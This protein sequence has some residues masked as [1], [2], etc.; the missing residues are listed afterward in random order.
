MAESK[1]DRV[2]RLNAARQRKWRATHM[3]AIRE[4]RRND[5]VDLKGYREQEQNDDFGGGGG[6]DDFG[7][8]DDDFDENIPP[9]PE[10]EPAP[11]RGR[12]PPAKVYT[13]EVTLAEIEAMEVDARR[14]NVALAAGTK[15]V[16]KDGMRIVFRVTGSKN[17]AKTLLTIAKVKKAIAEAKHKN[18]PAKA[19]QL[20]TQK[21]AVESIVW[22]IDHLDLR[23]PA[24][25]RQSYL[26]LMDVYKLQSKSATKERQENPEF[27]VMPYS[28]Y[29]AKIR[30][31][32]GD[33]S[34]QFVIASL[35][36][37]ATLRDNF[38][39]LVLVNDARAMTNDKDNY[40]IT[41]R[42]VKSSM[43]L[44]INTYKTDKKYGVIR[45]KLSAS[46]SKLLRTYIA[47]K[48]VSDGSPLF[49]EN[50][51]GLSA[52]ISKMTKDIAPGAKGGIDYIR[53][54]VIS[55]QLDKVGGLSAEARVEL[56]RSC[57]H[58]PNAQVSYVRGLNN[59][60]S[61]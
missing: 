16:R 47:K 48:G 5:R 57:G 24:P 35:Y 21:V 36:N 38:Y 1:Y 20:N 60:K 59:K 4:K 34:K 49:P 27:N 31:K 7:G 55:E 26:D 44:V 37:E 33:D 14:G 58:S 39:N 32:H 15:K 54:S 40:L 6:N 29:L 11:K 28:E 52:Y 22:C 41:P 53:Q 19:L 30:E 17:L 2:K 10:P 18:N 25:V 61:G 46:L 23:L 42:A 12:K 8:G 45:V 56:A 13:E 51:S 50:K 3:E 43:N 9:A